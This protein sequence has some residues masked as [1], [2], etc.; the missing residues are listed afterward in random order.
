[1]PR[2]QPPTD[3]LILGLDSGKF[4]A[5]KHALALCGW[6]VHRTSPGSKGQLAFVLLHV[7]CAGDDAIATLGKARKKYSAPILVLIR[8]AT[9]EER[10]RMLEAGASDVLT[11]T[12]KPREFLIRVWRAAERERDLAKSSLLRVG[13]ISIDQRARIALVEGAPVRLTKT[14]FDIL[15]RLVSHSPEPP[16]DSRGGARLSR[17]S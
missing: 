10:A 2:D 7:A 13:P 8:S 15:V 5:L 6:K 17:S 14:E 3:R 1:M 12:C 16:G 9:S 4:N 11:E